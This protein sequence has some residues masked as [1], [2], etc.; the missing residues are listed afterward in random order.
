MCGSGLSK[1]PLYDAHGIFLSYGCSA[2]RKRKLAGF[3]AEVLTDPDYDHV[4]PIEE[5]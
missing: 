5:E 4:E 2:C 1:R 3:R